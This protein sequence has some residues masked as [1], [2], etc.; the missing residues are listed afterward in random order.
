[1]PW[2]PENFIKHVFTPLKSNALAYLHA[3]NMFGAKIG[4]KPIRGI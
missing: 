2:K 1:V 3:V 4:L